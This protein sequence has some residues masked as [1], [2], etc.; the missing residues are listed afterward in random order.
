MTPLTF[1]CQ[2]VP[3]VTVISMAGDLD[4][5]NVDQL[6]AFVSRARRQPGDHVVLDLSEVPHVGRSGLRVLLNVRALLRRHGGDHL[7]SLQQAPARLLNDTG[8]RLILTVHHVQPGVVHGARAHRQG[9]ASSRPPGRRRARRRPGAWCP[10]VGAD[11]DPAG[12][13]QHG[14]DRGRLAC[15]RAP[16][17]AAAS[18]R[19][20]ISVA[21]PVAISEYR[22]FAPPARN[23]GQASSSHRS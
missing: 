1:A 10:S 14:A 23:G 19:S 2:H 18:H 12:V 5:A 15:E 17:P 11:S 21:K 6:D 3:G 13:P 16:S 9:Q 4:A 7:A 20:C 22:I 8:A